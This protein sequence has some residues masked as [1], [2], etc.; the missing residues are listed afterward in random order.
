VQDLYLYGSR[1]WCRRCHGLVYASQ[2]KSRPR[3]WRRARQE[4]AAA[5]REWWRQHLEA[6]T[7]VSAEWAQELQRRLEEIP[8]EM[9]AEARERLL[10]RRLRYVQHTGR[11]GRPTEKRG[12]R[13]N[14]SRRV[15]LQPGEA[16]CCRCR[17]ARPYRYPRRAEVIC[18]FDEVTGRVIDTRTAIR[19]RCRVCSAP[20][21]RIV[22]PGEAE[23]LQDYFG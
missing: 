16:Y 18:G 2:Q 11:P 1:F 4:A 9:E 22:R 21:F 19:A 14:D 8:R 23:G 3:W 5:H 12:Y 7:E 6:A 17:A 10:Q 13:H 15:K 20:V